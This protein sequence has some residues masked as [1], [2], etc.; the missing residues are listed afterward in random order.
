M[1]LCACARGPRL[2]E[3]EEVVEKREREERETKRDRKTREGGAD[4]QVCI[5]I[6]KKHNSNNIKMTPE[7]R[8]RP[9]VALPRTKV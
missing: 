7:D 3:E 4:V 5:A 6:N 8:N 2:P 9:C 1:S